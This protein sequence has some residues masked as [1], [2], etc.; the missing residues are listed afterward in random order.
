MSLL[1][2]CTT[3]RQR[4]V[5]SRVEQGMSVREIG[6]ELGINRTTVRDHL[7]AVKN[8]AQNLEM[9]TNDFIN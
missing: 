4:E 7:K 8:T 3:E 6:I 1:Q 5:A 2:F 9:I